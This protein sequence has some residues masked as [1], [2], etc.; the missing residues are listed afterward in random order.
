MSELNTIGG[1]FSLMKLS[2]VCVL[3]D[4]KLSGM[5][6][7]QKMGPFLQPG[8]EGTVQGQISQASSGIWF[9]LELTSSACKVA[10]I[11]AQ[12]PTMVFFFFF[13]LRGGNVQLIFF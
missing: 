13:F 6:H 2:S 7:C 10:L 11:Q 5:S 9:K 1:D 4:R 3:V 12:N 8:K